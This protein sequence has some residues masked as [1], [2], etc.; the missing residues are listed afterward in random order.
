VRP[1]GVRDRL[2]ETGILDDWRERVE[3][4][5]EVVPCEFE[6]WFRGDP[7]QRQVA[8]ARVARL[9]R[10]LDGDVV[11]EA[12]IEEIRYHAVLARL[13]VAAVHTILGTAGP[14][15]ALVQ[16]EQIRFFR[17]TGQM[18]GVIAGNDRLVDGVEIRSIPEPQG[19]P[20]VGLLDGLPLQNHRRLLGR[21]VV[22]DPDDFEG[23]YEPRYRRHGTAMA[24]LIVHGDLESGEEALGQPLYVRPIL[25][26][27]PH[28]WHSHQ[29]SVPEDVLVVDLI[30]RAVRRIIEGDGAEPP[31]APTV[32]VIN[33]SIGIR[34]RPFDGALSPLGRLLDWLAWRYRVL[35]IVSAGNHV[36]PIELATARS[37]LPGLTPAQ[38]EEEVILSV[39]RTI[40]TAVC[41][42]RPKR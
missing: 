33:L 7:Q 34:D 20:V 37:G 11:S 29:E 18:A 8:S 16:C 30:Y 22:D 10:Q 28:D 25:R 5:E 14:E 39:Q 23:I 24:S 15:I 40:D 26:P 1:W 6:L 2:L 41:S 31:A 19:E 13:P 38:V 42:R 21:L 4:N 12:I 3:H 35:F 17:A 9:V 32:C 27:D 36:H